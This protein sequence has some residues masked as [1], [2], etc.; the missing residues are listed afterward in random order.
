[1]R[2]LVGL[3]LSLIFLSVPAVRATLAETLGGSGDW[4]AL[5]TEQDGTKLCYMISAPIETTGR[6]KDR[7][8]VGAMVTH[9]N[10]GDARDQVSLV[11]GYFPQK[12]LPVRVTIGGRNYALTKFQGDRIW[13]SGDE[14]DQDMV[15]AM[16]AGNRMTVAGVTT[17]GV[18]VQDT[19]SLKGFTKTHQ[20]ISAACGL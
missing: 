17:Q 7:G 16:K 3:I 12:G 10:G 5:T 2:P 14:A 15:R 6:V 19:F 1:M 11:L 4:V 20:T 9:A 18:K 8:K 13:T